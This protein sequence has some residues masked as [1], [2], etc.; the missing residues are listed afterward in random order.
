[1]AQLLPIQSYQINQFNA[2]KKSNFFFTL[3]RVA[4][5]FLEVYNRKKLKQLFRDP[6]MNAT[7]AAFQQHYTVRFPRQD[8]ILTAV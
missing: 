6:C 3:E 5:I 7:P 4:G 8:A 2:F 1:M